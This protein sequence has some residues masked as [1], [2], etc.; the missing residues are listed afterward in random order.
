MTIQSYNLGFEYVFGVFGM[1]GS[2]SN[3]LALQ[4]NLSYHLH[5][6]Q[7]CIGKY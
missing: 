1:T 4:E 6:N 2:E 7:E 3:F 5:F